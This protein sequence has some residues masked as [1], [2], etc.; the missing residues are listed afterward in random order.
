VEVVNGSVPRKS[1]RSEPDRSEVVV[2]VREVLWV[3]AV[4]GINRGRSEVVV[5]VREV[6]RVT[7]VHPASCGRWQRPCAG[8]PNKGC[9]RCH[10]CGILGLRRSWL[11]SRT[12]PGISWFCGGAVGPSVNREDQMNKMHE[13]NRAC[14][15]GWAKWWN[16]R[17]D[18]AH[19]WDRCHREPQLVLSPGEFEVIGDVR[20]KAVCVLASGDHEVAFALSGMGAKVTSVDISEE[21]LSIAAKRAHDLGLDITF[22]RSDVTDLSRIADDTFIL[23][24]TGGGVSCWIS[25]LHKYYAEATRILQLKGRFIVNE[26]HPFCVLFSQE[27]PWPLR[28]YSSR[29]PFTYTSNEGFQGTEH[30][31][32]VADRIQTM[33]DVGCE[34][35]KVEE[36]EG[37]AAD[38]NPNESRGSGKSDNNTTPKIPRYLLVVGRKTAN[39]A[40]QGAAD[41]TA[42]AFWA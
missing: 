22:Y 6:L 36:H 7:A 12:C 2:L 39:K 19:L 10:R 17:A 3:T 29:G 15:N 4:G 30:H 33:L 21:Q 13:G 40:L 5:L 14:W 18:K 11:F 42:A 27:E 35:V 16:E 41:A 26:F 38:R 9:S 28:D 24:H 37:T 34:I 1:G 23:V 8:P 32:T 20:D 31:W 25:D